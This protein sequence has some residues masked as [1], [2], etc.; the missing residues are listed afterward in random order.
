MKQLHIAGNLLKSL[1]LAGLLA[2]CHNDQAIAP[3][4]TDGVA[5]NDQNAKIS[6]LLRLVKE[7][8][9]AIQYIKS[10]KFLGKISRID[11][12][13]NYNYYFEYTYNDNNPSGDLWISRKQYQKG[14]NSFVQ[15]WKYKVVNGLCVASESVALGDSYEYK[16]NAQGLLD[17]IKSSHIGNPHVIWKYSYNYNAASSSY[18][19]HKVASSN[20]QFGPEIETTFTYTSIPAKYSWNPVDATIYMDQGNIDRYLPIFGKFSD[21][22]VAKTVEQSLKN[23]ATKSSNKEFTY[24]TDSDGLVTSRITQTS[25]GN[26]PPASSPTTTILKYSSSWQGIP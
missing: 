15:E 19:L 6:P 18:R 16:Y 5:V 4:G 24:I 21:V 13:N 1:T 22:L 8:D 7:G 25:K 23:P 2:A 11:V 26:N 20:S 12:G 14:T 3:T 10:G 17:E 9:V